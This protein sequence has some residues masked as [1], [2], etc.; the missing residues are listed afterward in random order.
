M[1][2]CCA[3]PRTQHH[4]YIGYLDKSRG[5]ENHSKLSLRDVFITNVLSSEN[6]AII[7]YIEASDSWCGQQRGNS[8]GYLFVLSTGKGAEKQRLSGVLKTLRL[9]RSRVYLKTQFFQM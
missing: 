3:S 8:Q 9:G 7:W 4:H 6:I 5:K 1:T 2:S